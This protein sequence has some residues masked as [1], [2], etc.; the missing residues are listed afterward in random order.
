MASI[1]VGQSVSQSFFA[2]AM[3]SSVIGFHSVPRL[4]TKIEVARIESQSE[5][6]AASLVALS[7][8]CLSIVK[9]ASSIRAAVSL[10]LL[11]QSEGS[12]LRHT[13]A[14]TRILL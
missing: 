5:S 12:N 10:R 7:R 13:K 9:F 1:I 2:S 4:K 3:L 11:I 8:D 6:Q 14:S